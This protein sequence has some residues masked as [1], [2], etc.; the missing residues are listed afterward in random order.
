MCVSFTCYC[1]ESLILPSSDQL[2]IDQYYAS[3]AASAAPSTQDTPANP[4]LGSDFGE[5]EDVKPS[6]E[7]LD[8]LN[9]YRKRSRSRE[10]EGTGSTSKLPRMNGDA[11][12]NGFPPAVTPLENGMEESQ[13]SG[14]IDPHDDP[15]V[16]G[17]FRLRFYGCCANVTIAVN[18]EPVPFSQ[19]TEEH[20][21]LMTPE[22]YMAYYE[23]ATARS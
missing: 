4:D 9:E 18:G 11:N 23:V 6:T 3:L 10:D 19:V 13:G 1:S 8:S 7:Y 17:N 16:Y 21:E 15:L 2:D 22:E 5:E 14:N 12:H 20:Q